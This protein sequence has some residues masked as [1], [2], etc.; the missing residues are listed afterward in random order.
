MTEQH[1]DERSPEVE[2]ARLRLRPLSSADQQLYCE[3]YTDAET[4]RHIGAPMSMERAAR[5]FSAAVRIAQRQPPEQLLL[6]I[7]EKDTRQPVGICSVQH[8]ET[9]TRRA[10]AGIMIR[11]Q[12]WSRGYATEGLRAVIGLGFAVFPIDEVW[13]RIDSGHAVVERL[14]ISVGLSPGG[15]VEMAQGRPGRQWSIDRKSWGR[16]P[17]A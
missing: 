17:A 6:A 15:T 14:V 1:A 2:T 8:V 16:K 3:L 12:S 11:R 5:S 10:E 9:P 7:V 13:V 4:M